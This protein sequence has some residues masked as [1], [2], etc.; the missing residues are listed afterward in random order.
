[1]GEHATGKLDF[2]KTYLFHEGDGC[3]QTQLA[4]WDQIN[5]LWKFS[6]DPTR[7]A[8]AQLDGGNCKVVNM[9]HHQYMEELE[10]SFKERQ[11]AEKALKRGG[12]GGE[13]M[14]RSPKEGGGGTGRGG[15][16]ERGARGPRN[17]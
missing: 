3:T 7:I 13:R 12:G 17:T 14:A 6:G 1:M 8:A 10:V 11:E 4:Y 5:N 15:G 2:R 9:S 16:G